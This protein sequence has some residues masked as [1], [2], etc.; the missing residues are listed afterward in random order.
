VQ[1]TGLQDPAGIPQGRQTQHLVLRQGQQG[2]SLGQVMLKPGEQKQVR[3]RLVYPADATPPQVL[4]VQ[5]V[6]QS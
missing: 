1:T 2:P 3:V 4:T 5:P 6:K